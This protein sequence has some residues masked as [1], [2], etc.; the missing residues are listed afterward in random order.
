MEEVQEIFLDFHHNGV[1]GLVVKDVNTSEQVVYVYK[2]LAKDFTSEVHYNVQSCVHTSY[3]VL[4]FA[5]MISM[6]WPH[7]LA[8]SN[9]PN[10]F[11]N[12]GGEH[13]TL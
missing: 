10:L 3:H 1:F 4:T 8:P 13:K 12:E 11:S 6:L 5:G 7:L 9:T 2:S